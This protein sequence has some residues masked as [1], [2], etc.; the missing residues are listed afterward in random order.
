MNTDKHYILAANKT[1]FIVKNPN[2]MEAENA[3][4]DHYGSWSFEEK[5][6]L[7]NIPFRKYVESNDYVNYADHYPTFWSV[8]ALDYN[9]K[10]EIVWQRQTDAYDC[11]Y[12]SNKFSGSKGTCLLNSLHSFFCHDG[13]I[14]L[15]KTEALEKN[16]DI[17]KDELD[18]MEAN[19][20]SNQISLKIYIDFET[21]RAW[22]FLTKKFGLVSKNL[23]ERF[24]NGKAELIVQEVDFDLLETQMSNITPDDLTNELDN[25]ICLNFKKY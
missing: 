5:K 15:Q 9:L 10:N 20:L 24:L 13:M 12:V 8:Y 2:F 17:T 23:W 14:D 11:R 19:L 7:T 16:E 22:S 6:R 25:G 4:M 18:E 1:F 3:S 21:R